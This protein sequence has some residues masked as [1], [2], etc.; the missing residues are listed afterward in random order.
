[1]TPS[2]TQRE[3]RCRTATPGRCSTRWRQ[4]RVEALGAKS[5]D[6][7]RANLDD[8][9][10]ARVR[11]D[12]ITRARTAEEVPLATA[13][14]LLARQRL[15]GEAPPAQRGPGSSWLRHGLRRRPA[16]SSM[17]WR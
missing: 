5:M 1:M 8:L 9:A 15:T 4:A 3:R 10:E 7:V 14:G 2:C 13:V 11:L 17:R 12:A 16:Q 6:G